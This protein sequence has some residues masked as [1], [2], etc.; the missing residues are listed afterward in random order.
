MDIEILGQTFW[1]NGIK[2]TVKDV[3]KWTS[4]TVQSTGQGT[5]LKLA[6]GVYQANGP[7]ISSTTHEHQ[8]FWIV[9]SGGRQEKIEVNGDIGNGQTVLVVWGSVKGN[10][11]GYNLVVRNFTTNKGWNLLRCLPNS[12]AYKGCKQLT[13]KYLLYIFAPFLI[14][15]LLGGIGDTSPFLAID[16]FVVFPILMFVG[17]RKRNKIIWK[18]YNTAMACINQAINNNHQFVKS[19]EA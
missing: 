19:L 9:S 5:V 1:L 11:N 13:I 16:F 18:N 8:D 2:G 3:R 7:Q 10:N 12:I 15:F 17:Y 14:L 4:T 6:D